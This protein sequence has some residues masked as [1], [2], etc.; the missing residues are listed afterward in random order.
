MR[1]VVNFR[2]RPLY[3]RYLLNRRLWGPRVRLDVLQKRK[4]SYPY[5]DSNPGPSS[6]YCSYHTDYA[7]SVP[8][9]HIYIC[10]YLLHC[11]NFADVCCTLPARDIRPISAFR[12]VAKYFKLEKKILGTVP[13]YILYN[14]NNISEGRLHVA[15]DPHAWGPCGSEMR[16]FCFKPLFLCIF[17]KKMRNVIET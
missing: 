15:R 7:I 4:I 13:G 14:C 8:I 2:L 6:P 9:R 11:Y 10:T 17:Y 12:Q 5:R 1:W 16:H 3:H